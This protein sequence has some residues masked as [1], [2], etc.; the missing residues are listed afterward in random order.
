MFCGPPYLSAEADLL[1]FS[2][3]ACACKPCCMPVEL[4]SVSSGP[5][6]EDAEEDERTAE[7]DAG[8]AAKEDART[9][10]VC[11]K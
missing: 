2:L 3:C 11:F 5:P 8:A 10:R 1:T 9:S 4:A 7:E 6:L